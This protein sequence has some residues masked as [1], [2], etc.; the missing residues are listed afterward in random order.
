[1]NAHEKLPL[2]L[3]D[4]HTDQRSLSAT[5]MFEFRIIL[6]QQGCARCLESG[7][8]SLFKKAHLPWGEVEKV[9]RML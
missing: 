9:V 3:L 7:L 1:M 6:N 2:D 8:I 4:L 5:R